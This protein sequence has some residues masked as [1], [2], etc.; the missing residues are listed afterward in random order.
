[1]KQEHLDREVRNLVRTIAHH[2]LADVT[3]MIQQRCGK[4]VDPKFI[5]QE[6]KGYQS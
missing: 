3:T 5:E 4:K 6:W 2:T 1:M